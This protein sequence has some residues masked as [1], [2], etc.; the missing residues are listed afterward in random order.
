M[1][2]LLASGYMQGRRTTLHT[3]GL[4]TILGVA[5]TSHSQ[6]VFVIVHETPGYEQ[7]RETLGQKMACDNVVRAHLRVC[8]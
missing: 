4:A 6:R 1:E 3:K 7:R 5:A 2:G 8:R